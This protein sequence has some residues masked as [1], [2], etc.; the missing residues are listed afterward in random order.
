ILVRRSGVDVGTAIGGITAIINGFS[1]QI[2]NSTELVNKLVAADI[3]FAVSAGDLVTAF[4]RVGSSAQDAGLDIDELIGLIT[5]LRQ[6][7]GREA[8][9]I[10]N[11]LKTIFT[12]IV[13]PDTLK[14]LEQI[15]IET[16]YS[17]GQFKDAL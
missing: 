4:T 6:T 7:T 5:S 15:G 16:G 3:R 12:R 13:R 10:G 14:T 9:V 11:S 1:N 17:T 2:I 8:P